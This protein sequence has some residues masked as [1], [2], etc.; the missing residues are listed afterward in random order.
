MFMFMHYVYDIGNIDYFRGP[1]FLKFPAGVT[2]VTFHVLIADDE[3]V[4]SNEYIYFSILYQSL[5]HLVKT[6]HY[7]STTVY[8]Q[9]NDC[10]FLIKS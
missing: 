10:K 4:E 2:N 8:I 9:D 3:L 5:H 7:T 1:F 6:F